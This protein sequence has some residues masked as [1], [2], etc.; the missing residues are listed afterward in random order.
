MNL[1]ENVAKIQMLVVEMVDVPLQKN[2][3]VI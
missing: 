3:L 1:A 2:K